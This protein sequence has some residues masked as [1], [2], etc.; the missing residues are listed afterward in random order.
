VREF[1]SRFDR[2]YNQIPTDYRLTTSSIHFLYMNSF[3]GQFRYILKDRD[4]TSLVEAKEFSIDIEENILDSKIEPFQ[5]PRSKT[6]SRTKVSN[7]NVPHLIALLTQKIDQ[8]NTQFD[9]VKNHLMNHMNT[10]ERNQSAPRPQFTRQ[11]RDAI[12]WKPRPQQE[13]KAVDTLKPIG[14]IDIESWCL[15]FQETH[16]E[17]ECP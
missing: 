2:L 16:R 1:I 14:T 6:K 15:P 12:S 9:Q 4:P 7:N 10:V 11:H 8:M 5:Y 13:A 17:D 3:E